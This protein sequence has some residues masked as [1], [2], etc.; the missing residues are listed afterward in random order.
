MFVVGNGRSC[1]S[2][3][4]IMIVLIKSLLGQHPCFL[5][6]CLTKVSLAVMPTFLSLFHIQL[7][8]Y[9][10]KCLSF[11]FS[12]CLIAFLFL[13]RAALILGASV[14]SHPLLPSVSPLVK[15]FLNPI[16][17]TQHATLL[18]FPGLI[19]ISLFFS[20]YLVIIMGVWERKKLIV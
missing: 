18:S 16:P 20:I 12:M 4:N 3:S 5:V 19:Y 13:F 8:V 15:S 9:F 10:W 17:S 2:S 7:L 6:L 1:P 14:E 11:L